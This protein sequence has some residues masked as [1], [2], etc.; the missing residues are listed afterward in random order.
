ML[1]PAEQVQGRS[2]TEPF[3]LRRAERVR[4]PQRL[5]CTIR[6]SDTAR[7]RFA[8]FYLLQPNE[9]EAV[10]LADAVVVS[11]VLEGQRQQAL[12]LQIRLMDARIAPGD[13]G[14]APQKTR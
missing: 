1:G 11:R 9:A 13:D 2:R 7:H 8:R 14:R 12:L 6:V 5:G 10:L 3:Q 4:E